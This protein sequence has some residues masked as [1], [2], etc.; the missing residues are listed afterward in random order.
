MKKENK[1][2]SKIEALRQKCD[3]YLNGWKRAKADYEN[4]KKQ[5]Q[6]EKEE[7]VKFAN[8][9]LIMQLI[10][11]YGNLKYS[12]EHLPGDFKDNDWVK[13]IEH[14]KNQ[15]KQV[16][17]ENGVEEI[18]PQVGDGFNP[19]I[20]EA[21]KGEGDR[22]SEKTGNANKIVKVISGGYKLNGKVIV[23]AKVVVK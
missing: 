4:L 6:K 1:E 7:F 21:V 23:A 13:G 14:I 2:I 19:E 20:H 8:L 10:P 15:F 18:N 11:V 9:N 17:E 12:F 22:K 3:E 16:L 5:T